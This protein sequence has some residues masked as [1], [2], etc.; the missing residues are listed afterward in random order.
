MH[1]DVVANLLAIG[2]VGV[3]TYLFFADD[4][5]RWAFFGYRP[6]AVMLLVDPQTRKCIL[7]KHKSSPYWHFPQGTVYGSDLNSL[8]AQTILRE[9][10]LSELDFKFV[11]TA[12]LGV[13]HKDVA[14]KYL[15]KYRSGSISLLPFQGKAYLGCLVHVHASKKLTSKLGYDIFGVKLTSITQALRLIDPRKKAYITRSKILADLL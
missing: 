13:I 2:T 5:R 15:E 6:T 14:R 11:K 4:L 10:G 12:F 7:V 8:V 9:L 3:S 1:L